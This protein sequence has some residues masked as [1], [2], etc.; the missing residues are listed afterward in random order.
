MTPFAKAPIIGAK[1]CAKRAKT[2]RETNMYKDIL[3]VP[4]ARSEAVGP[5]A[6]SLA[7]SFR[8][9]LRVVGPALDLAAPSYV[10]PEMPVEILDNARESVRAAARDRVEGIAGLAREKGIDP[11]TEVISGSLDACA[12]EL[13]RR[14]R[15]CDLAIVEQPDR[16]AREGDTQLLEA[17]LF[18]SGRPLLVVPFIQ[19]RALAFDNALVAWDESA[20][21][22]RAVAAA[23]PFLKR[24]NHVEVVTVDDRSRPRSA[25]PETLARHLEAHGVRTRGR[26][27]PNVGDV[28]DTLLSHAADIGA[29]YLVMGGYGHSR[30]REFILGGATR[31]ILASMTVPILM[32]H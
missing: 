2:Q 21:A 8:A 31:G 14:A 27:L 19:K 4:T 11:R 25:E 29:D 22:A 20:T 3:V 5:F 13:A 9:G 18:G 16:E 30:L 26:R 15:Y 28:T 23:L 1:A 10:V 24:T 12:H 6:A 7:D 32:M 17:I